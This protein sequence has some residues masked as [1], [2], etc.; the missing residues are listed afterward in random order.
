VAPV[1]AVRID[2]AKPYV[3]AVVDGKVVQKTVALGARG[4]ASLGA[5]V[6]SVV[7]LS[8]GLAA[9]TTLLRGTVGQ[10]REGTPVTIASAA[11][12]SAAR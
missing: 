9:G 11:A 5:G 7:E 4:E 3:L 12:A 6:E 1:S 2:Q 8:D 10:L